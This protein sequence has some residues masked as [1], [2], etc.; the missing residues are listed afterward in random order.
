M[1]NNNCMLGCEDASQR[2]YPSKLRPYLSV[3]NTHTDMHAY[4]RLLSSL[5]M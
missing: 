1:G 4:K 3:N 2:T 5:D